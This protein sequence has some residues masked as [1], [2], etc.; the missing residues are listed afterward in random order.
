MVIWRLGRDDALLRAHLQGGGILAH[1]SEAV[2]GLGGL[3]LQ[4]AVLAAIN[5]LKGRP[6][7]KPM[8]T[9]AG[10]WE[11]IRGWLPAHIAPPPA[12]DRPTSYLYPAGPAAPAHLVFQG[13]IGLRLTDFAPLRALCLLVGPLLSTSANGAGQEPARDL[14]QLAA[15]FPGLPLLAGDLGPAAR[16]SQIIDWASGAIVRT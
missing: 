5:G 4:P 13:K 11:Q 8:L 12:G 1:P 9:V 15:H 2:Y 7:T 6:A 16:P 14:A 10:H 3:A